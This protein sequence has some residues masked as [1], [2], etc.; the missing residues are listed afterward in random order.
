MHVYDIR[1]AEANDEVAGFIKAACPRRL[2]DC[3]KAELVAH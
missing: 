1:A 3:L 2:P